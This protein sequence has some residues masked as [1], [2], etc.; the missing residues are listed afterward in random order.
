MYASQ[1]SGRHLYKLASDFSVEHFHDGSII[2]LALSDKLIRVNRSGADLLELIKNTFVSG[3]FSSD[4]LSELIGRNYSVSKSHAAKMA[5]EILSD[6][7]G[8]CIFIRSDGRE[9]TG[10]NE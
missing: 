6:W 7:V 9:A 4:D 5:D 10:G 1:I 2:L 3:D 8:R